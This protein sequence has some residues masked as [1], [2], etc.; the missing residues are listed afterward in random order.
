M[1]GGAGKRVRAGRPAD[2]REPWTAE[3]VEDKRERRQDGD[4]ER[5][6]EVYPLPR[7]APRYGL[8]AVLKHRSQAEIPCADRA[9]SRAGHR[10]VRTV[11]ACRLQRT[12]WGISLPRRAIPPDSRHPRPPAW[13]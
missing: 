13:L 3:Q 8:P 5:P 7:A 6:P 1:L 4:A 10:S 12:A 2:L 9:I 11:P